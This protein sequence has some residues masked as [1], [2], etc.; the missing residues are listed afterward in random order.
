MERQDNTILGTTWGN[1]VVLSRHISL[2]YPCNGITEVSYC[3]S[4][5]S[6]EGFKYWKL[7]D[8]VTTDLCY[9]IIPGKHFEERWATVSVESPQY[10]NSDLWFLEESQYSEL[11][12][13]L[14]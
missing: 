13:G 1:D 5:V 11:H 9:A 8:L 3:A 2:V 4:T 14:F 6:T 12:L 10:F 7:K